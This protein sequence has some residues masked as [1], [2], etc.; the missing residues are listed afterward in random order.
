MDSNR[1]HIILILVIF[2]IVMI[3][4]IIGYFLPE[5]KEVEKENEFLKM[6]S[7]FRHDISNKLSKE[8]KITPMAD[9]V[10]IAENSYKFFE[11][12]YNKV[13]PKD[14]QENWDNFA[15]KIIP[16]YNDNIKSEDEIEKYFKEHSEQICLETGIDNYNDFYKLMIS[17]ID[18]V[19]SK[20]LQLEKIGISEIV[21]N[22]E[23]YTY[24]ELNCQYKDNINMKFNMKVFNEKNNEGVFI[25]YY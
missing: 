20:K 4:M 15:R 25:I 12:Y 21:T 22:D 16:K 13:S 9:D 14:V 19:D 8:Q 7:E 24:A 2:I 1:K 11:K 10:I 5:K 18:S 3:I 6:D 23:N 17:I